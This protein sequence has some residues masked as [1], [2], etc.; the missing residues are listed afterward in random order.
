MRQPPYTV[1][2]LVGPVQKKSLKTLLFG[3]LSADAYYEAHRDD[4]GVYILWMEFSRFGTLWAYPC[5]LAERDEKPLVFSSWSPGGDGSGN[6][7]FFARWQ[8]LVT[9]ESFPRFRYTKLDKAAFQKIFRSYKAGTAGGAPDA[10]A[11]SDADPEESS[12]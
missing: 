3:H 7:V 1:P 9:A 11:S 5:V 6:D 2:P 4:N 12:Q 10:P 8:E